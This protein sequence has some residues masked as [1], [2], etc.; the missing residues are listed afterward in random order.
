MHAHTHTHMHAYAC[1]QTYESTHT[2][3]HKHVRMH[4]NTCK[5]TYAHTR[6]TLCI[7]LTVTWKI[8]IL[9]YSLD[10]HQLSEKLTSPMIQLPFLMWSAM[11]LL[12]PPQ[13]EQ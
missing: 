13:A 4:A 8:L 1:T 5:Y 10:G 3:A 9:I 7:T 11:F 12:L 2:N 6:Y